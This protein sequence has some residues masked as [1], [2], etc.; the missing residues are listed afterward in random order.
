MFE[1]KEKLLWNHVLE[2]KFYHAKK[3]LDEN[4]IYYKSSH[5]LQI[6][7]GSPRLHSLHFYTEEDMNFFMLKY[8]EFFEVI[9]D[10]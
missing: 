10:K 1:V 3:F 6:F 2:T 8:E 7:D 9:S 5:T 4:G